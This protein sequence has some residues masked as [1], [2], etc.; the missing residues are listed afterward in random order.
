MHGSPPTAE[1]SYELGGTFSPQGG[2]MLLN[3]IT[4][5][6]YTVLNR[7]REDQRKGE[8]KKEKHGN[9]GKEANANQRINK[10]ASLDKFTY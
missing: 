2:G 4:P 9:K 5:T 10:G 3:I 8:I 7:W 1:E 6:G